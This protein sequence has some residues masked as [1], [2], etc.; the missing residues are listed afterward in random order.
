MLLLI[1][2]G[3]TRVKWALVDPRLSRQV[4]HDAT[5][6]LPADWIASGVVLHTERQ[7]LAAAWS[8]FNI[9]H[10]VV[11][12]V[13]GDAVRQHLSQILLNACGLAQQQIDW[14]TSVADAGGVRNGYRD[15]TQL[16]CDRFAALI[17]ARALFPAQRLIVAT[18]GTATTIDALEADGTFLGGLILPGPILMAQ[19]LAQKTAQLPQLL[20]I[21]EA[22][23]APP[24]F[25]DHTEAAIRSGCLVAHSGA[26]MQAL[27][28]HVGA[29]CILSGGAAR[30]IAP[31]VMQ[32]HEVIDN[33]VLRGLQASTWN[34]DSC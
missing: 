6:K 8:D 20:Q 2:A 10:V 7:N 29:C 25:A 16:G 4:L 17:G 5:R 12:N 27:A 26:I 1:D 30:F 32:P 31:L 24:L 13:A 9:S 34:G 15:P 14:F 22:F 21:G 33:L 11:A 23:D 3:N 28:S 19:S 18:C